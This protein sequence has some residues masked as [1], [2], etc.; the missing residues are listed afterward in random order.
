AA[1]LLGRG[2]LAML[3]NSTVGSNQSSTQFPAW[4]SA[5]LLETDKLSASN[6]FEETIEQRVRQ[7]Y[8]T[9]PESFRL[10]RAVSIRQIG[11]QAGVHGSSRI[12]EGL[13]LRK[14]RCSACQS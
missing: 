11:Y 8:R 5:T 13:I 1:K 6:E 10:Q 3:L 4:P 12:N 2:S 14:E 7:L 9:L